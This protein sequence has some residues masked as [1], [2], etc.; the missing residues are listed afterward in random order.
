[1]IPFNVS[2]PGLPGCV[3]A[4]GNELVPTCVGWFSYAA[5]CQEKGRA[6]ICQYRC[7]AKMVFPV[8]KGHLKFSVTELNT[9]TPT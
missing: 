2:V 1:M 9:E 3:D 7:V 5:L 8:M 6:S 4:G